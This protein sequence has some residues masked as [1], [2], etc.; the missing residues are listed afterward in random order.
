[1]TSLSRSIQPAAWASIV[2]GVAASTSSTGTFVVGIPGSEAYASYLN[3]FAQTGGFTNP[4]PDPE[5]PDYYAVS[6]EGGVEGLVDVFDSITT[7]LVRA[8][9]IELESPPLNLELVNV[10]ID[11]DGVPRGEEDAPNWDVDVEAEPSILHLK[12]QVC[13]RVTNRGAN[14]VD[15]LYGC[16]T[17][18]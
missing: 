12:D 6:A 16:P 7:Q 1:M 3:T 2:E 15:V 9:D 14:R 13:A 11:C 5:A 17:I 8:C 4:E 10:Y 18:R